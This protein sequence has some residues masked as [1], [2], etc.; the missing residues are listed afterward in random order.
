MTIDAVATAR[1]RFIAVGWWLVV[2]G[3]E[4][5]GSRRSH[6]PPTTN[7]QPPDQ[8]VNR[9][10]TSAC[11][12]GAAE[13]LVPNAGESALVV[14][15]ETRFFRLNTLNSCAITSTRRPVFSVMA[16]LPRRSSE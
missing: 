5:G 16:L 9:T 12:I 6:E 4:S 1:M 11:R 2:S 10:A 8:N 3:P 15:A 13:T 14:H 7:H